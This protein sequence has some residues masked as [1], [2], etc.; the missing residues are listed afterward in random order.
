MPNEFIPGLIQMNSEM[1]VPPLAHIFF[2]T[3]LAIFV[4]TMIY[5]MV[6]I[7]IKSKSYW[8]KYLL[9]YSAVI[10]I[11]VTLFV[12]GLKMPRQKQIKACAIGPVSLDQIAIKYDVTKV[13]GKELTLIERK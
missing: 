1:I 7:L 11:A 2:A 9:V 8:K 12:Y 10:L 3:A 5:A 13:N 4:V 6:S